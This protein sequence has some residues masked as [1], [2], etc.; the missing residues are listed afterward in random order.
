MKERKEGSKGICFFYRWTSYCVEKF[1]FLRKKGNGVPLCWQRKE[2]DKCSRYVWTKKVFNVIINV[3]THRWRLKYLSGTCW[4]LRLDSKS[5][6]INGWSKEFV[7]KI[8]TY[9]R[10]RAVI[11]AAASVACRYP[12]TG[13]PSTKPF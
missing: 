3:L 6:L 7:D 9:P 11:R 5:E 12:S 10:E 2:V 13:T 8:E 1:F 4:S